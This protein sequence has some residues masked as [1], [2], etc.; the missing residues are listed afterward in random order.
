MTSRAAA[1]ESAEG[2]PDR[3][4][5]RARLASIFEAAVLRPRVAA[6]AS[7]GTS[8]TS[9]STNDTRSAG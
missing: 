7:N 5:P 9:W 1:W 2:A 8:K 3:S 6:I 4:R